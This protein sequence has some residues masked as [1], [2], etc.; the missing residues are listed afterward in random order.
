MP[1]KYSRN[2]N[3]KVI[4]VVLGWFSS[5]ESMQ[6][7]KQIAATCE[8]HRCRVIFFATLTDLFYGNQND[9]CEAQ[10][11]DLISV[12]RFDAIC[13]LAERF[14]GPNVFTELIERS[15]KAGVPVFSLDRKI[16]GCISIEFDYKQAFREIVEHMVEVHGYREIN[17]MNGRRNDSYSEERLEAYREVLEEHGIAYD[18]KRVY[19][20][21]FWS[22]PTIRE[23]E[24]MVK[25][26]PDMPQAIVCAND[27]MAI[28]VNDF[29]KK[30]GFCVPE[31]IATSGFDGMDM[32]EYCNPRLTTGIHDIRGPIEKAYEIAWN[33]KNASE[34]SCKICHPLQIGCSCGCDGKKPFDASAEIMRLQSQLYIEIEFQN[35]MNEM[36]SILAKN[37]SY[38]DA[39]DLI[40]KR[41]KPINYKDLWVCSNT[42]Q[43]TESGYSMLTDLWER[44][45]YTVPEGYSD[46]MWVLHSQADE[47][48]VTIDENLM[49]D[50]RDLIP[51]LEKELDENHT[52]LF[53]TMHLSDETIG[54]MGVS[55]DMETFWGNAYSTFITSFR[56]LIE[57]HCNQVNLL[58]AYL[59]D[60][61]TNLY[62]R[63]GFFETLNKLLKKYKS[64]EFSLV[65]MDMDGL[66][67]INDTYGHAMGDEAIAALG[68]I[69]GQNAPGHIATRIGGDE[70]LIAILGEH[71]GEHANAIADQIRRDVDDYNIREKRCYRLHAS[72]GIYTDEIQGKSMD[73][74]IKKADA[75]MYEDKARNHMSKK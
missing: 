13:I 14:K 59:F 8:E 51:D 60:P 1:D 15:H 30:R 48:S 7:M 2:K 71:A 16:E 43:D 19:Y 39:M 47:E 72:I 38:Q 41:V 75:L 65:S 52:L 27:T 21:E 74:F 42:Q 29:L 10:I 56:Y 11:F 57:L 36:V 12:E 32:E 4:A 63:L 45:G 67:H 34:G 24:R 44:M 68:Q 18:P 33:P 23:M 49:I 54:Y 58:R 22:T 69:I 62:N 70:F 53:T 9:K 3:Y 50:R 31:D 46:R 40:F 20:G 17:F 26:W 28:T 35:S 73:D 55:C 64:G 66:K 61:L 5:K 37:D 25:E 6:Y